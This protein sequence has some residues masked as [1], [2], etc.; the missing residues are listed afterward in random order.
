MNADNARATVLA[1]LAEIAPEADLLALDPKAGMRE[2]LDIDSMDFLR[3][4]QEVQLRTGLAIPESDY[5]QVGSL[6]GMVGWM[7]AR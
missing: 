4:V 5:G 2:A 6:D 7:A 1:I 3:L